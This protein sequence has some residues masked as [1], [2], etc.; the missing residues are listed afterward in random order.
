MV[1]VFVGF[2]LGDL[3][4]FCQMGLGL[5]VAVVLDATVVRTLLV[6][7]IMA[8]LGDAQLV[9]AAA[10]SSWVPQLH[11]ESPASRAAGCTPSR[12]VR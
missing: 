7:S 1:A 5:A 6:P 4:E 10:G 2:A 9:P 3:A 8:L 12:R 11:I